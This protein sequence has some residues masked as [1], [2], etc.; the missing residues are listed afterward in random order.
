MEPGGSD[1]HALVGAYA[2]DAVSEFERAGFERHLAGCSSCSDEVREL[3]EAT[4]QL[5]AAAAVVPRAELKARALHAVTQ[6]RQLPPLTSPASRAG[7]AGAAAAGI[8]A[9]RTRR[10]A[11]MLSAAAA[12]AAAVVIAILA[13]AMHGD[14][15]Q[16]DQAQRRSQAITAVLTAA[17]AAMLSAPVSTGGTATVVM[18]HAER[19]LVFTAAGLRALPAAKRYELWLMGP[20]GDK[21][22]GM[23]A[24]SRTGMTSP[25]VVSGLAAGDRISLTVEPASGSKRPTS[26]PLLMLGLRSR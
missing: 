5:G 15:H 16:L 20:R 6:T 17:D 9:G 24:A 13:V 3:R 2:M 7:A 26:P 4:A 21:A 8:R 14:Q 18:S 12:T 1:M 11:P 22:A 23:L 10:L 25:V 19:K